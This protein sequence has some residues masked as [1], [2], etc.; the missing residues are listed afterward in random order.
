MNTLQS[1]QAFLIQHAGAGTLTIAE[2]AKDAGSSN[3]MFRPANADQPAGIS[4]VMHRQEGDS[5][6]VVTDGALVQFR[7]SFNNNI[8]VNDFRKA[9]NIAENLSILQSATALAIN[10]RAPAS[11]EDTLQYRLNR[12][13]LRNYR[14]EIT[15]NNTGNVLPQAFLEDS[16]TRTMTPLNMNGNTQYAFAVT[17]DSSAWNPLRFRIVFS[18]INTVPV[19]FTTV[20]ANRQQNNILVQ[21]STADENGITRYRVERSA[22]GRNFSSIGDVVANGTRA[23]QY[24]LTDRQPLNGNNFYRIRSIGT[25]G[26]EKLS[27]TVKV[28]PVAK[29]GGMS[30]FPNP[31]TGSEINLMIDN[32]P[33]GEY[34]LRIVNDLGQVIESGKIQHQ[35]ESSAQLIHTGNRL[36]A[37]HYQL[38]VTG[39]ENGY[40]QVIP[41][42]AQ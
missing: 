13:R 30:I 1:G 28:A 42:I 27:A 4:L 41:F 7:E 15:I 8:D 17:S 38:E 10:K 37:G 14:F 20:A 32:M 26:E 5:S 11:Q 31:V 22:D 35:S 21:W 39:T 40:R 9:D 18:P 33:R 12:L 25:A 29:A 24:Q 6:F 2:S 3:A 36:R 19:R 23:A 34:L 16:H